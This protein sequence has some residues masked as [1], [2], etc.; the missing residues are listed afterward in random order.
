MYVFQLFDALVHY[1]SL[2]LFWHFKYLIGKKIVNISYSFPK[3]VY[4]CFFVVKKDSWTQMSAS[5][6]PFINMMCSLLTVLVKPNDTA[7][8]FFS[9]CS[10]ETTDSAA[11]VSSP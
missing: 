7:V 2:S 5:H 10:L 11:P 8:V 1:Y 9:P 4:V 6:L 3:Y